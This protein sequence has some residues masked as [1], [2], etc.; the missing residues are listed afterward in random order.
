MT[1]HPIDQRIAFLHE[2]AKLSHV[3][4]ATT[5]C[6]GTRRENTG[7]HSWHVTL[8]ALVLAPEAGPDV[9]I[10]RVIKMLLIHDLVEIDTGDTPVHSANGQAHGSADVLA[11][12]QAAAA[13]IFGLLPPEQ[14]SAFRALWEEFEAAETPDALYAKAVDRLQPVMANLAANGGTWVEYKVTRDQL[15]TRVGSKITRGLPG[16]WAHLRDRIDAWFAKRMA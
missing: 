15:E 13:R 6:D 8:C 1:Q 14:A 9:N 16:V 12:E 5:L 3:I 11:A 10:D 7:E 2:A 4:R